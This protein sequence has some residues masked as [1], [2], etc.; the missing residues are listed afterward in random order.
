M[1]TTGIPIHPDHRAASADQLAALR[2][3]VEELIR[4]DNRFYAP[5][6]RD[7]GLDGRLDGGIDSLEAFCRAMPFTTKDELVEDQRRHPPYG[8]NLTFPLERYVRLHQTSGSTGEPLRWL[9]TVESWRWVYGCWSRVFEACG[10][11]ASDR[12]FFPF[13]FGPFLG[14]WAAFDAAWTA[15]YLALPGGGVSSL[16]R[17]RV[18]LDNRSTVVCCTPT[19]AIRLAEIA[20]EE[21]L[22]LVSSEVSKVIVAGEPGGSLPAVRSR[23]AEL[24]GAEVLDHHGMTEIGPVSYPNRRC[25]G[26]LHVI[27]SAYLAEV[28]DPESGEP[29]APGEIGELVLTN[30]GRVGTPLLRYRTGDLVRISE[31]SPE[32]LGTTDLALDGGILARADDMV[33]VRGVNL[34]PSAVDR[35]VRRF[36]EVA[37]YRVHLSTDRSMAEVSLEIEPLPEAASPEDAAA[38]ADRVSEALR[39]HLALRIPVDLAEVGSLPRFELKARRW[40]RDSA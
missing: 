19:Y 33:V 7:A 40:Q 38:L 24:W 13:S 5:R 15:G 22:D 10:L 21:G 9:D 20:A 4:G 12:I 36:P 3:L 37:E 31:R 16:G 11:E 1:S 14:F 26:I 32:E 39:T 28:L 29:V 6:L 25:P 23:I 27:E 8:S 2:R 35:V 34:Y 30:L 18:M 17:L